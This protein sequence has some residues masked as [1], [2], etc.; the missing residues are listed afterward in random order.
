MI[1]RAREPYC[2]LRIVFS[3]YDREV[4]PNNLQEHVSQSMPEKSAIPFDT[5]IYIGEMS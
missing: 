1:G 4:I 3:I 5:L 2:C